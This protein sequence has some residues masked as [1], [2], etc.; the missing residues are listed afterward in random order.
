[1]DAEI[2]RSAACCEL[3][4]SMVSS[5]GEVRLKVTGSSML[6]VVWPG[7]E[8]AVIRSEYAELLPGQIVLYHRNGAFTAHRV[9]RIAH[10]H[11]ITRG[12]SL[13][14]PDL[15]VEPDEIVGRVVSIFRNG[16][17]IS[18]ER[19][20][21]SHILSKILQRSHLSRRL[22]LYLIRQLTSVTARLYGIPEICR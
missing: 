19:S 12:D 5:F 13:L 11:L 2:Q 4:H 16:T 8:I 20:P 15:P 6:P 18:P 17:D 9:E 22:V 3:I 10:D 14:V 7:D 1:M 21:I